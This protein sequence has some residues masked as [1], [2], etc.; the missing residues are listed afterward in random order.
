MLDSPLIDYPLSYTRRVT[1][2]ISVKNIKIG[3]QHPVVIQ[4]MLT[5]HTTDSLHC[6][7]QIKALTKANCQLIRLSLLHQKDLAAMPELLRLLS[8]EGI[9]VPLVADVHFAANLAIG[10]CEF[11]DK[12]RINPGNFSDRPKNYRQQIDKKYDFEIGKI[13]LKERIKPLAEKLNY[14]K[15]ALR[16]GVN[17][18]SLS[19]RMMQRYGDSPLAMV[20]SALE[21]AQIFSEYGVTDIVIS[22]K[23]SNPLIVQKAYRLFAKRNFGKS[24]LPLHLGVTEA[25]SD[26]IGRVKSLC[27]IGSLLADG[28]GDTIRVSLTEDSVNEVVFAEGLRTYITTNYRHPKQGMQAANSS[29]NPITYQ[30][31]LDEYR[32]EHKAYQLGNIELGNKSSLKIGVVAGK[33]Q[34]LSK[35]TTLDFNYELSANKLYLISDKRKIEANFISQNEYMHT[36]GSIKN[37]NNAPICFSDELSI[38][39]IRQLYQQEVINKVSIGLFVSSARGKQDYSL[40]IKLASLIG[41]GLLDFILLSDQFTA[42]D[43]HRLLDVL[44]ATRARLIETDYVACPSCGRTMFDLPAVTKLIKSKTNHLKGVKI[45]ILGCMVNGPGEMADADFGYVGSSA[46]KID[47]YLGHRRVK[48]NIPTER[49]LI[50]LIDLIKLSGKWVEPN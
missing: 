31:L 7:A 4:S 37:H 44:Q 41:E 33:T 5:S 22:L 47:L 3:S 42:A 8:N 50:E 48:K 32:K 19:E 29:A 25:G 35:K 36:K 30:G 34:F 43:G 17:H 23:S 27:G 20:E 1:R 12:I 40:E 18:G 9:A 13:K 16:I 6:L 46:G 49:A 2:T 39:K 45:G 24:A 26:T 11:F 14:Y 38:F 10:A 21:M 15:R 28:I